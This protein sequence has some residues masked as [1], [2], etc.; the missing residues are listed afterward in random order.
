VTA[1][2][3]ARDLR[4][5]T[6]LPFDVV[7]FDLDGTITDPERGITSCV[8][9]A[10]ADA[11]I[12]VDDLRTLRGYIGPPLADGFARFH[13]LD[14]AACDRAVAAYR[15]RYVV[16]GIFDLDLIAGMPDLLVDLADAGVRVA[17]CTSKVT[18]MATSILEHVGLAEV[19]TFVG[20][21]TIDGRR[22]TKADVVAHT[23]ER[24]GLTD[25]DRR[26]R[27]ALVGDRHHDIDGARAHGLHAVGVR[28]GFAEPTELEE[29]GAHVIVDDVVGLRSILFGEALPAG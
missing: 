25:A 12:V 26:S 28:W 1:S 23:L 4:H 29:A 8:A 7:L 2:A 22:S 17:L 9:H 21:A 19:V 3:L 13:G 16:D 15:E 5:P 10:L 24:L 20:G 6:H 18:E 27:V 11:G 14:A